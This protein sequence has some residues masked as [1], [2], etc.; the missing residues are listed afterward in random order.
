[1]N[2]KEREKFKKRL[3]EERERL[4]NDLGQLQGDSF[5]RSLR[6]SSGNLSGYS[7]HPADAGDEDYARS[8][9]LDVA[10]GK[11]QLLRE[12]DYALDRIEEGI[13]G[14]C[15]SCGENIYSKRLEAKPSARLC[16]K[17]TKQMEAEGLA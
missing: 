10:S 13:Y 7:T 17:C 2:K 5:N 1:M 8:F 16:L 4:L 3:L 15:D 9:S 12:I 6:D 11:Q 14:K